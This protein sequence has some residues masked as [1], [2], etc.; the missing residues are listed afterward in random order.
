MGKHADEHNIHCSNDVSNSKGPNFT[1][2]KARAR[3]ELRN[4]LM[5]RCLND[6]AQFDPDKAPVD[7][8][9][10]FSNNSD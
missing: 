10:D 6:L 8:V 5:Q 4:R 1:Q 7:Q 2:F 3:E 9:F